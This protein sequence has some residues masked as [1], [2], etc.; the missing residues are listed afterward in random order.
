MSKYLSDNTQAARVFYK[1][2]SNFSKSVRPWEQAVFYEI[3]PD[4]LQDI[5]LI[6]R[7]VYGRPGEYLAVMAATGLDNFDMELVQ[8][9]VALPTEAQLMNFKR[10]SGYESGNSVR[11]D[12]W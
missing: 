9:T 5:T 3:K 6:S 1:L 4:E 2:V 7:R 12:R 10:M 11:N 8:K